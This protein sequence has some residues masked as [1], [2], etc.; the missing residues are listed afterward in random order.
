MQSLYDLIQE[1]QLA[2]LFENQEP[3]A[4]NGAAAESSGRTMKARR[5][6]S[7]PVEPE[8]ILSQWLIARTKYAPV[9]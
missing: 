2:R 7:L 6:H 3:E 9:A 4:D 8:R 5:V 1:D